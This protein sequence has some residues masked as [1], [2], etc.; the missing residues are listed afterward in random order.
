MDE[1]VDETQYSWSVTNTYLVA[2]LSTPDS[3][4]DVCHTLTSGAS[5][6]AKMWV[7]ATHKML[8]LVDWR[9]IRSNTAKRATLFCK[10]ANN[11]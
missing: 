8:L 5:G 6:F 10:A 7:L 11:S 2:I 1:S 3:K 9:S 4:V